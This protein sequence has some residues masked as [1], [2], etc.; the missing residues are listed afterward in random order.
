[1]SARP[2]N[3]I[4]SLFI[5]SVVVP[6]LPEGLSKSSGRSLQSRRRHM[7]LIVGMAVALA[8]CGRKGGLDRPPA[9]PVPNDDPQGEGIQ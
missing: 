4:G 6:A 9:D 8:A 1:M 7:I 5:M 3:T 2:K